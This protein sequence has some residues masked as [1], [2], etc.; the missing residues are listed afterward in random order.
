MNVFSSTKDVSGPNPGVSG[1]PPESVL[2]AY[3]RAFLNGNDGIIISLLEDGTYIDVNDVFLRSTGYA[4]EDIIG[5]KSTALE[6]WAYDTERDEFV[7]FLRKN[8]SVQNFLATFRRKD[9]SLGTVSISSEILE[10]SGR[11]CIVSVSRDISDSA[12]ALARFHAY[13]EYGNDLICTFTPDARFNYISPSFKSIL[14]FSRVDLVG[15]P[16]EYLYTEE[17]CPAFTTAFGSI[18]S[19]A[20]GHASRRVP[21]RIQIGQRRK[22]LPCIP[23]EGH[24]SGIF[25]GSGRLVEVLFISRSIEERKIYEDRLIAMAE[26]YKVL[27]EAS[28]EAIVF[29][30]DEKI[31][32][33]NEAASVLTGYS[34]EELLGKSVFDILDPSFMERA[35]EG[36][37]R[38]DSGAYEAQISRKDGTKMYCE[39]HGRTQPIGGKR[40][41]VS[42]LRDITETVLA[43]KVKQLE[44]T[45]SEYSML[46]NPAEIVRLTHDH[47]ASLLNCSHVALKFMP[48]YVDIHIHEA[49]AL[50]E[51]DSA[52][53][54]MDAFQSVVRDQKKWT[55]SPDIL[56]EE[57]SAD[58]E[59]GAASGEKSSVRTACR[60]MVPV[61]HRGRVAGVC[62]LARKAVPFLPEEFGYVTVLLEAMFG[63]LD[64]VRARLDL[65][66]SE[67]KYRAL[68]ESATDGIFIISNEKIDL[69]NRALIELLGYT[70]EELIGSSFLDFVG[71]T[72]RE[73]IRQYYHSR[74]MGMAAPKTYTS[75]A[76]SKNGQQMPVEVAICEFKYAGNNDVLVFI[77]DITERIQNERKL[78][79]EQ[80]RLESLVESI[81][82]LVFLKDVSGVYLVVNDEFARLVG[83]PC[84]EIVGRSDSGV[85]DAP[86]SEPIRFPDFVPEAGK[87]DKTDYV[88]ATCPDS[89]APVLLEINRRIIHDP[90]G[91]TIGIL[92]VAHD[93]TRMHMNEQNARALNSALEARVRARTEE[94]ALLNRELESFSYSASHDLRAPVRHIKSFSQILSR[95][96]ESFG[97]QSHMK[98]YAER[99]HAAADTMS[100]IIDGL[101][102]LSRAGSQPLSLRLVNLD[103]LVRK[104]VETFKEENPG[105]I[106]QWCIGSLPLLPADEQLLEIV[107]TNLLSNALKYSSKKPVSIVEI[108]ALPSGKEDCGAGFFVRDNGTGF[109]MED[110]GELFNAFHRLHSPVEF[111]G[112]G[113][114]LA[115]VKRILDR[116]GATIRVQAEQEMGATFFVEYPSV[117]MQY[118]LPD[119]CVSDLS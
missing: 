18:I 97:A 14:G 38:D 95:E 27:S 84:Q 36:Y 44:V 58:S 69:V 22:G 19:Q 116:H 54:G 98:H 30:Q 104:V 77:R 26:R 25:D 68:I 37:S 49:S 43:R 109:S 10:M 73:R 60:A 70:R 115:T 5:Q 118:L 15:L 23:T 17:T 117:R 103:L 39:I 7:Q 89:D 106:I 47:I 9:R 81:P 57:H 119:T 34:L 91:R 102:A 3:R 20:D 92:G 114:G 63:S 75:F 16:P 113:I 80:L 28:F 32:E 52:W 86:G 8:G 4:R 6:I 85:F 11:M 62:G 67:S 93:V 79:D 110:A 31:I 71:E 96:L 53:G 40:I 33:A 55:P 112:S 88:W 83:K 107:M 78:K 24:V 61:L 48:D 12:E 99:I 46:Y 90:S 101:L 105:R 65:E 111:A 64:L 94:L 66:E 29:S 50:N 35:V 82:D 76:R 21:I 72:E 87:T 108:G 59:P 100:G 2:A 45:I 42:S 51:L 41:R 1:M 74:Q 13:T 56:T